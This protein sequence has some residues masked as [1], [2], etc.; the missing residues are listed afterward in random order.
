MAARWLDSKVDEL[1]AEVATLGMTIDPSGRASLAEGLRERVA[2]TARQLRITETAARRLVD[3]DAVRGMAESLV[4]QFAVERPGLDIASAP[5]DS[6]V[7]RELA[8][9]ALAALAEALRVHLA[10][11]DDPA[12]AV[13]TARQCADLFA[14]H[15]TCLYAAHNAE[16]VPITSAWLHRAA[17]QIENAADLLDAGG[18]LADSSDVTPERLADRFRRDASLLRAAAADAG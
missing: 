13:Q 7:S 11:T 10:N 14:V 3:R 9:L 16:Q 5:A 4:T 2:G 8:S 1:V 17:R 18:S 6:V 12:S 15:G